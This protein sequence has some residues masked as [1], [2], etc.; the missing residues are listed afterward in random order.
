MG[1]HEK[2]LQKIISG[3]QDAAINFSETVA[4]LNALG[5]SMR[6]NGSHHIF[7]REGVMEIINI[8]PDGPKAKP[9]QIKQIRE[10]VLKY[11]LGAQD[12]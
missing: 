12:E 3:R 2:F 6:R 9:Y 10:I 5:F 8:Q 11:R 1:K 7:Y 4:L